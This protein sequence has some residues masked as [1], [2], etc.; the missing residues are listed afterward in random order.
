MPFACSV[1]ICWCSIKAGRIAWDALEKTLLIAE[2]GGPAEGH[3]VKIFAVQPDGTD[4]LH[5]AGN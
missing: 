5:H 2:F 1:E 3:A 4:P